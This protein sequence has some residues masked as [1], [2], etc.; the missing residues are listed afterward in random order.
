[1]VLQA[2]RCEV[3]YVEDA[4]KDD[5]GRRCDDSVRVFQSAS[6]RD[7]RGLISH[8]IHQ[9]EANEV[10]FTLELRKLCDPSWYSGCCLKGSMDTM[11]IPHA[12]MGKLLFGPTR[13]DIAG[14]LCY[15]RLQS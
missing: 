6:K 15:S 3:C 12:L 1:M 8:L 11:G 5:F 14:N 9:H 10:H 7:Y 2:V 13:S 4:W